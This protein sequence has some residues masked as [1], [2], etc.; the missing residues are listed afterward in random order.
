MVTLDSRAV[1][2]GYFCGGFGAFSRKKGTKRSKKGQFE[3][4]IS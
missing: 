2:S 4:L 3:L 1:K